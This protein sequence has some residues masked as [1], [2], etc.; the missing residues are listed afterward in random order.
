[1]RFKVL[2]ALQQQPDMNQRQLA[3]LLGVSLGKANYLLHALLDK[4]LPKA[5]NF[6][7]SQNKLAYAYLLTPSGI[8]EKSRTDARLPGAQ[9][10]RIRSPQGRDRAA[11]SRSH[12]QPMTLLVTGGAGFIGSNFVLDW[13]SA[14]QSTHEPVVTLD[15]LTYAGNPENLAALQGD[16]SH[17]LVQGDICDRVLV[18]QLLAT[19]RPRAIVHFTAES[20]VGRSI[21]GP[22]G[23]IR[24]N[25]EGTFTLLEAA[26]AYWRS[27]EGGTQAHFR[28]QHVFTERGLA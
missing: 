24:T 12:S 28:L 4:G 2:H 21:D 14:A 15:A 5:C 16:P 10:D 9:D 22:G 7:N 17:T 8:A 23:F 25:V 11:A 26:H 19:N 13:F 3:E 27:L 20:H 18:D 6:R 1:M